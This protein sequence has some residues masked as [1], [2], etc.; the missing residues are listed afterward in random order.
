MKK[1]HNYNDCYT[2]KQ[3]IGSGSFGTVHL[4][5]RKNNPDQIY[6]AKKTNNLSEDAMQSARKEAEL[7]KDLRHPHIVSFVESFIDK[8][9]FIIIMEYCE[10]GDLAGHIDK[11]KKRK[12]NFPEDLILNWLFQLCVALKFIHSKKILHRDIK[13]QNIF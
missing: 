10:E 2:E 6:V 8:G 1:S 4:V 9:V 12:M 3:V 13:T 11:L 7:L 5:H